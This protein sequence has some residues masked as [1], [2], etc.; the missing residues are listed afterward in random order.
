MDMPAV[1]TLSKLRALTAKLPES[2]HLPVSFVEHNLYTVPSDNQESGD[3]VLEGLFDGPLCSVAMSTLP[4]GYCY[5]NHAHDVDEWL[6]CIEGEVVMSVDGKVT[7]M[8]PGTMLYIPS[9]TKHAVV[10]T[11]CHSRVVAVTHPGAR[12]FPDAPK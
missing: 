10:D 9:N 12:E 6:V 3:C 11:P 5:R 1:S 7:A 4:K 2:P 8:T